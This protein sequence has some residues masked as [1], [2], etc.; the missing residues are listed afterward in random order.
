MDDSLPDEVALLNAVTAEVEELHSVFTQWYG[1]DLESLDR[2]DQVLSD[3]FSIVMPGGGILAREPLMSGLL[4]SRGSR[5]VSIRIRNVA[6][7]RRLGD[8]VIATYEEWQD[9]ADYVTGRISTVVFTMEPDGPN[10]LCWQH[11]HETWLQPPPSSG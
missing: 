5:D 4:S 10:G 8:V 3:T 6:V 2:V 1:D 11:V 9:E 7:R